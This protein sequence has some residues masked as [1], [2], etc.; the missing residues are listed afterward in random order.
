MADTQ[1]KEEKNENEIKVEGVV[2]RELP[3]LEYEVEIDFKGL[4][5]KLECYV[6]GRMKKNFIQIR[7]GDKVEVVISLYN[8]DKGRI[9]KRLTSRKVVEVEQ[10]LQV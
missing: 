9:V 8:I 10:N 1:K 4:K 2:L 5:H 6:S 7:K 3:A